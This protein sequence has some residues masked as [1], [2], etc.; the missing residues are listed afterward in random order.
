MLTPSDILHT[1]IFQISEAI[2]N[3]PAEI[4]EKIYKEF[5]AIK[6]RERKEMGWNEVNADIVKAPFCEKRLRITKVMF[7]GYCSFCRKNGRCYECLKYRKYHYLGYPIYDENEY[8]EIF[9]KFYGAA[10]CSKQQFCFEICELRDIF[11]RKPG[12]D[13]FFPQALGQAVELKNM[14]ATQ[15]FVFWPK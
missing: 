9:Q 3:L 10:R 1:S 13:I 12:T 6:M 7:C 15:D 4:C 14:D 8:D 11:L 5:V 2:Q